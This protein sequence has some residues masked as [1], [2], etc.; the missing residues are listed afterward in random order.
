MNKLI[1]NAKP[2]FKAKFSEVCE[3]VCEDITK[4]CRPKLEAINKYVAEEFTIPENVLLVEDMGRE[5]S[6]SGEI[7]KSIEEECEQMEKTINEVR[8]L[9]FSHS[10]SFRNNFLF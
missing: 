4:S 9:E 6:R 5:N 1:P 3:K 10:S 7:A 8:R 2:D